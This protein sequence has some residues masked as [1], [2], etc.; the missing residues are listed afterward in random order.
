[1]KLVPVSGSVYFL[2]LHQHSNKLFQTDLRLSE[3]LKLHNKMYEYFYCFS[4]LSIFHR[5][6][7]ELLQRAAAKREPTP[8]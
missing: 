7:V 1:M 8:N 2:R 5:S 3:S 4:F 6:V